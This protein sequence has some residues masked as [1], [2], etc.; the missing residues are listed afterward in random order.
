MIIDFLMNIQIKKYFNLVEI[1]LAIGLLA[2]GVTVVIAL[3]P[4]GLGHSREAIGENYCAETADSLF[5][6]ITR[7]ANIDGNWDVVVNLPMTKADI[8]DTGKLSN[9][10]SFGSVG[11]SEGFI[12]F[13]AFDRNVSGDVVTSD[14]GVYGIKVQSENAVDFTGEVLLWQKV[15]PTMLIAGVSVDVAVDTAVGVNLEISWPVEVPYVERNKNYYYF[16]I[17]N[18]NN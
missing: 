1:S 16:E 12:Y 11:N 3:F 18:S 14:D 10:F 13:G 4:I 5:A 6:Y 17:Y 7:E 15:L 2:I 8:P 9:D